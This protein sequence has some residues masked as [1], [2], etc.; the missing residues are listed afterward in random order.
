[1]MGGSLANPSERFPNAFNR[2]LWKE[3][4]YLLACLAGAAVTIIG[5]LGILFY[6]KE[7]PAFIHS[8]SVF[9]KLTCLQT[10]STTTLETTKYDRLPSDIEPEGS[11]FPSP[12][13]WSA[14]FRQRSTFIT[15]RLLVTLVN[16]AFLSFLDASLY[17]TY[18]LLLA[19]PI[20]SGGLNFTPKT[21]GY[22]LG[23]AALGHGLI[24]GFCFA[25]ILKRWGVRNVYAT[26]IIAYMF[27]YIMMPIMNALTRRAGRATP[28]V[29]GLIIIEEFA[30]FASYSSYSKLNEYPSIDNPS[31]MQIYLLSTR[32]H[33]YFCQSG[34][35]FPVRSR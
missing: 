3:H 19:S 1:M 15:R 12:P 7:V 2:P 26:S 34:L 17:A 16:Y 11:L 5:F 6:L 23:A 33:V 29:W 30:F 13:L 28:L 35:A 22:I 21:I 32:L 20:A 9:L 10:L 14:L 27:M 25:R 8:S 4:P 24:Q 31:L 18:T